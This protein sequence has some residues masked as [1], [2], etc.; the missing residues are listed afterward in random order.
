[1]KHLMTAV[2][3][4][5]A[6]AAV[7]AAPGIAGTWKVTG[8]V[9][10]NAVVATLTLTQDGD[11]LSGTVDLEGADKPSAVTGTIK[12]RA[13]TLTFDLHHGGSTYT[14]TWAGTLGDDDVLKG[15]ID[16]QGMANGEFIAKKP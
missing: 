12:D 2:L 3:A 1:M 13:V 9:A 14:N 10:G 4:T 5:L 6:V 7:I 8:D 15:S 16:V 11:E